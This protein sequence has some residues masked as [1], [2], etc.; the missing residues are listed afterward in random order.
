MRSNFDTTA[1]LNYTLFLDFLVA[2]K[3]F[4]QNMRIKGERSHPSMVGE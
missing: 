3:E 1:S 2:S 4:L